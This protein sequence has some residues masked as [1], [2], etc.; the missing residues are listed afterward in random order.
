[1]SSQGKAKYPLSVLVSLIIKKIDI[2]AIVLISSP[3]LIWA[4]FDRSVWP[5]DQAWYGH[6]SVKLFLA[7]QDN[8]GIYLDKLSSALQMK[9]PLIAWIGQLFVPL[10]TYFATVESS[11][12]F[13]L[14]LVSVLSLTFFYASIRRLFNSH[15]RSVSFFATFCLLSSPMFIGL[16]EQFFAEAYQTLAVILSLYIYVTWSERSLVGN[17]ALM[18]STLLLGLLAKISTPFYQFP[19]FVLSLLE[20]CKHKNNLPRNKV[21][22]IAAL[23]TFAITSLLTL[24]WYLKNLEPVLTFAKKAS[25]EEIGLL[26]S[27]H[28]T[29]ISK[30]RFWSRHLFENVFSVQGHTTNIVIVGLFI[31]G[32]GYFTRRFPFKKTRKGTLLT[33]ASMLYVPL[34]LL[35]FS[36]QTNEE[37]RYIMPILVYT[38]I[39]LY[40]VFANI[41]F[42]KT[43]AFT[44]VALLLLKNYSISFGYYPKTIENPWLKG[45]TLSDEVYQDTK[46]TVEQVCSLSQNNLVGVDIAN[47]NQVTY[48]F[49]ASHYETT[50]DCRFISLGWAEK[51]FSKVLKRL[52]ESKITGFLTLQNSELAEIRDPFNQVAVPAKKYF[53]E[54]PDWRQTRLISERVLLY[55]RTN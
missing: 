7:L 50:R 13:S 10:E 4:V 45:I 36:T 16:H 29:F 35:F 51:D 11:L 42:G 12:L 19:I 20:L 3:I 54:H 25:G 28:F 37:T 8:P 39:L 17:L 44:S 33:F 52:K 55:I 48:N 5:W 14:W 27:S 32:L 46:R 23:C 6:E 24:S 53:S 2:L 49:F 21:R 9:A 43:I 38:S 31:V 22:T 41:R 34:A 40:S 47:V 18:A 1:M 30:L 15:G 26:Y